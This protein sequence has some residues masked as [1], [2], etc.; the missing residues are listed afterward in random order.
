MYLSPKPQG[1]TTILVKV[2]KLPRS[3]G[4]FAIF[5]AYCAMKYAGKGKGRRRRSARVNNPYR[6]SREMVAVIIW[7]YSATLSQISSNIMALFF[8]RAQSSMHFEVDPFLALQLPSW[9]C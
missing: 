7:L 6:K 4:T 8:R 1:S 2:I 9:K 3:R 5:L